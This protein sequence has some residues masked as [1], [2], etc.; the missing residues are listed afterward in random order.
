MA[1]QKPTPAPKGLRDLIRT[2]ME[3]E[4]LN[5]TQLAERASVSQAFI[6]R[7]LNG[8]RGAPADQIIARI[9]KALRLRPNQLLCE[10]GRMD[11]NAKVLMRTLAPLTAKDMEQVQRLAEKLARKYHPDLQ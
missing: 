10:A 1:T 3:R 6:S 4:G 11:N 7:L 9:E 5:T 8:D 2:A